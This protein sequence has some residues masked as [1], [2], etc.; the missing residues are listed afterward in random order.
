MNED[1]HNDAI[2]LMSH[3]PHTHIKHTAMISD[4]NVPKKTILA[5]PYADILML[6]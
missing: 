4:Y 3:R 5:F 1:L 6:S 2:V